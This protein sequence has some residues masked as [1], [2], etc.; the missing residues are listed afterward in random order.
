MTM[1]RLD[2]LRDV[3]ALQDRMSRVFEGFY[4]RPQED[5]TRSAWVP[6]VDIYSNGQH[7]LVLKAELP[8]MKEEEIEVAV[9]ENTLTLRGEKKL[10]R[11]VAEDQFH[12]IERSY[13]TFARTFALPPT[14]DA[15]KVKAEYKAGVLTV[16]LPLREEAK[17]KQIKVA[18]AA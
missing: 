15:D 3:A 2:S 12:R 5:L 14:V 18:V 16:R 17:P 9:E 7:E 1:V 13:G 4:G 6:A 11:E 8:D 10:D